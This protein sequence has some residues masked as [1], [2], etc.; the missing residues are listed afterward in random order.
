M[1]YYVDVI[2]DNPWKE[3]LNQYYNKDKLSNYL[4]KIDSNKNTYMPNLAKT[5]PYWILR[6]RINRRKKIRN[7]EHSDY[8]NPKNRQKILRK[9]D[10]LDRLEEDT[11]RLDT[12]ESKCHDIYYPDHSSFIAR[13]KQKESFFGNTSQ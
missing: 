9:G 6:D 12:F 13:C 1:I 3:Y 5:S 2:K 4:N 10:I 11:I 7:P 8:N